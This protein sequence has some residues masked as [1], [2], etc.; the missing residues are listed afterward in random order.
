M[1]DQGSDNGRRRVSKTP[2]RRRP[3]ST[4]RQKPTKPQKKKAKL[5]QKSQS[6]RFVAA[7]REHECELDEAAF[8]Q[9]LRKVFPPKS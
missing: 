7:A 6:E 1:S 3:K 9:T 2:P 5:S 8:D 4:S